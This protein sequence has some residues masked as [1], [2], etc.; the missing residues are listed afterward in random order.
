MT[1]GGG[2]HRGGDP[3]PAH[4]P[5]HAKV[6]PDDPP[7][8]RAPA[9]DLPVADS[10]AVA[11]EHT[12]G[13]G[14]VT[15]AP[16]VRRHARTPRRS[17]ASAH[18]R[19]TEARR[20]AAADRHRPALA[21]RAARDHQAAARD[22]GGRLEQRLEELSQAAVKTAERYSFPLSL[23]AFVLLFVAGQSRIDRRD[24]KLRLAPLDS[25]H[26]LASFV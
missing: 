14:G 10:G 8:V 19:G 21:Q 22:S 11:T 20:R 23:A 5:A 4:S 6:L 15:P 25:K 2:G 16:S 17:A 26:D 12:R 13:R 7:A 24:P 1:G 3:A 9:S 18:P